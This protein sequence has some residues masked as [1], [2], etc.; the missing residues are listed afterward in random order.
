MK[1]LKVIL[2]VLL[3]VFLI[4]IAVFTYQ[5]LSI[6]KPWLNTRV[7]LR[8]NKRDLEEKQKWENLFKIKTEE[9][10]TKKDPSLCNQLPERIQSYSRDKEGKIFYGFLYTSG[11]PTGP[12]RLVAFPKYECSVVYFA[13]SSTVQIKIEDLNWGP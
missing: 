6:E 10:I 1:Y 4:K 11:G 9:A 5:F 3:L 7:S 13:N 2:F 8:G 12:N